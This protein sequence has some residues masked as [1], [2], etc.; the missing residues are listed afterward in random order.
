M[1]T[2]IFL[3]LVLA[4]FLSG[5]SAAPCFD[6]CCCC[7]PVE[8]QA[9]YTDSDT[10]V[11]EHKETRSAPFLNDMSN[12]LADSEAG[13]STAQEMAAATE[14]APAQAINS[15]S[16]QQ[17]VQQIPQYPVQQPV[18]YPAFPPAFQAPYHTAHPPVLNPVY[19]PNYHPAQPPAYHHPGHHP[20]HSYHHPGGFVTPAPPP[21]GLQHGNHP[22]P[23]VYK[24]TD[25]TVYDVYYNH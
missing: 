13:A 24:T 2:H 15:A 11:E 14:G 23:R 4:M 18:H 17:P 16:S 12:G 19:H 25:Q 1:E 5:T 20:A 21:S 10:S 7:G 3:T 8:P 9:E 22:L 6:C